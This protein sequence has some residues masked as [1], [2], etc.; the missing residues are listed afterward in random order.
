M[1]WAET[2]GVLDVMGFTVN[3]LD[4][5]LLA[6]PMETPVE[7]AMATQEIIFGNRQFC[8]LV[9]DVTALAV[10]QKSLKCDVV[11]FQPQHSYN[12]SLETLWHLK[13]FRWCFVT[14]VR[15]LQTRV[16]TALR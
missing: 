2:R 10:L 8:T 9:T 4:R 14:S 13:N 16:E 7:P 11:Q 3:G 1:R 6:R 5:G 12:I 15:H